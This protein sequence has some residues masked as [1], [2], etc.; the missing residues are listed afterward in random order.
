[1]RRWKSLRANE[2]EDGLRF[3]EGLVLIVV[4]LC[5]TI[6][7]QSL[8]LTQLRKALVALKLLFREP[9]PYTIVD[10]YL[11]NLNHAMYIIMQPHLFIIL[12]FGGE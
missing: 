9:A 12:S 3:L 8:L 10:V 6:K 11:Q 7:R 4:N 5:W 2:V 1:M